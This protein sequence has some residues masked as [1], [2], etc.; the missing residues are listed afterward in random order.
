MSF[1]GVNPKDSIVWILSMLQQ[2]YHLRF[3]D[4]L[5]TLNVSIVK[6]IHTA[7]ELRFI[8][9]IKSKFSMIAELSQLP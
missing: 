5:L 2:F 1:V 3:A 4:S 6:P 7:L 9:A 8:L